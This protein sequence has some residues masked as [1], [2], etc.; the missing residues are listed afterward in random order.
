MPHS[1]I[2]IEEQQ[3]STL[4][5]AAMLIWCLTSILIL[6]IGLLVVFFQA[7]HTTDRLVDL[8][9]QRLNVQK[10]LNGVPISLGVI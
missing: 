7:R 6:Y 3:L 10:K 1:I 2:S 8:Q 4:I 5:M 9:L